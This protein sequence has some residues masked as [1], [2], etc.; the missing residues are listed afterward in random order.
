MRPGLAS[1]PLLAAV[2]LVSCGDTTV[3]AGKAETL[4]RRTV[5]QQVGA[6]V[7]SVT[8]PEG[9]KAKPDVTFTCVVTGRDG[10]KG[11]AVVHVKDDNGAFEVT[12]PFLH[13][14]EL[15]AVMADR[16]RTQTKVRVTFACQEIVI[17]REGGRFR[18]RATSDGR[19]GSVVVRF[20]DDAG[21][22]RFRPPKL[23]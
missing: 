10:S 20:I 5:T 17:V 12:V 1:L 15:E 18:C 16:L 8:C 9:V 11:N 6:R 2:A 13:V 22:F 7:A 23:R 4:I 14:R 19:S 3:D 21:H